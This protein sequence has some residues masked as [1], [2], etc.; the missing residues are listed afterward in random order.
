M[1]LQD[2]QLDEDVKKA[3]AIAFCVNTADKTINKVIDDVIDKGVNKTVEG[4]E[5]NKKIINV[6]KFSNKI[7]DTSFFTFSQQIISAPIR[8]REGENDKTE[9]L[10]EELFEKAYEDNGVVK[11]IINAKA[12]GFW[13]L[14][15]SLIKKDIRLSTRGLKIKSKQLYVKNKMYIPENEAL[16]QHHNLLI[17]GHPGYKAMYQTIQANYFWFEMAKHYKQYALNCLT[18]RHT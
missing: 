7:S 3:L 6:K 13:K 2:H 9:K 15:T 4:N 5:E 18:C 12:R 1:L 10:L 8:D 17:H 16:Q 14:P 11:E